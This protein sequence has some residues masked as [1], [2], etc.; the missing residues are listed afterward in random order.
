MNDSD[1]VI[2]QHQEMQAVQRD[3]DGRQP[4]PGG[5]CGRCETCGCAEVA[6]DLIEVQGREMHH[7]EALD[8]LVDLAYVVLMEHADRDVQADAA[9]KLVRDMPTLK[10]LVREVEATTRRLLG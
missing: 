4:D 3:H 8:V 5:C 2:Q 1:L 7:H 6:D 10:A 9:R